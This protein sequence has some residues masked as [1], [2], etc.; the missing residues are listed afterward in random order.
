MKDHSGK[1]QGLMNQHLAESNALQ[2]RVN[3]LHDDLK[4]NQ[5]TATDMTP[6]VSLSVRVLGSHTH[7]SNP[8]M[9]QLHYDEVLKQ[10]E[11]EYED[12]IQQ[13]RSR[14]REDKDSEEQSSALK[15]AQV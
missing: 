12:E 10:Q 14:R 6:S 2:E 1:M 3:G 9:Y 5:V 7:T 13:L 15:Q 8:P 11:K 4:A